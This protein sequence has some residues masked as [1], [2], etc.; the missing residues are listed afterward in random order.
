MPKE[1]FPFRY[2]DPLT[3]KW[4]RARYLA[5]RHEIGAR[6]KQWEITGPPEVRHDAVGG[7]FSPFRTNAAGQAKLERGPTLRDG[8]RYLTL[9]FL[10]RYVR[11][12]ARRRR[13]AQMRGAADLLGCVE[14][15][16]PADSAAPLW[17]R[18][19]LMAMYS[20]RK[21]CRAPAMANGRCRMHGGQAGRKPTHGRY[22]RAA[23]TERRAVRESLRSLR[24]LIG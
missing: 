3:G 11:Y 4:I 2:R 12:C 21:P 1:L 5:E 22:T 7:H 13:Y 24:K 20:R 18:K 17:R 6:Y 16:L 9:L 23:I 15:D 10:R 19:S 14:L 8:E